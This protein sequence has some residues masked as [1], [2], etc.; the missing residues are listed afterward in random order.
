M[1]AVGLILAATAALGAFMFVPASVQAALLRTGVPVALMAVGAA[2]VL[3]RQAPA[4]FTLILFGLV[5]WLAFRRGFG[6]RWRRRGPR[7]RPPGP[8]GGG[9]A[10]RVVR[11]AAL[12]T[13]MDGQVPVNG[14]VLAG[15]HE[16]ELLEEM[17]REELLEL[18]AEV[19][20]DA[21]SRLLLDAYLDGRFPRWRENADAD[22]DAGEGAAT[23]PRTMS[24]EE[25]HEVLGL[26]APASE[27]SVL[28]AYGRLVESS[29]AEGG[30]AGASV[31]LD[32][33]DEAKSVLLGLHD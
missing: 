24:L 1:S 28:E 21:D 5:L 16:S 3:G 33:L 18:R 9:E 32:R 23:R 25:A 15:N 19:G 17:T 14:V 6:G 10:R 7:P 11:T 30:D 31:S 22:R 20:F 8:A 29:A 27:A 4:G 2:L 12:E 26:E 13:E